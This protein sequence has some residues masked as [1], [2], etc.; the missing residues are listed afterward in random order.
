MLIEETN[1]F[2][3]AKPD[4]RLIKPLVKAR[5]FNATLAESDGVPLL[6]LPRGK[7][8]VDPTSRRIPIAEAILRVNERLCAEGGVLWRRHPS[9]ARP[10]GSL[11]PYNTG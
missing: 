9:A 11:G 5:R 6:L 8:A 1:A 4:A 3:A 10:L 7:A 2:A